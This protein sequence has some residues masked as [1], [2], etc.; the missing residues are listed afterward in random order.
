M[1]LVQDASRKAHELIYMDNLQ[2]AYRATMEHAVK[3]QRHSFALEF[4]T[5]VTKIS[6]IIDELLVYPKQHTPKTYLGGISYLCGKV[7]CDTELYDCLRNMG[8]NF[9]GNTQ[10]HNLK[11]IEINI[12]LCVNAYNR[13][14][15]NLVASLE[16]QELKKLI[17]GGLQQAAYSTSYSG[18]KKY[19]HDSVKES[20]CGMKK[21]I[22]QR[23]IANSAFTI[24]EGKR[25]LSVEIVNGDG[26]IIKKNLLSQKKYIHFG[27]KV[28]Y[29][30]TDVL[31]SLK[32]EIPKL[33]GGVK[34]IS[35]NEGFNGISL[36]TSEFCFPNIRVTVKAVIK[37]GL[38]TTK[39]LKCTV[40]KNFAWVNKD[41]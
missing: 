25:S 10:K 40:S 9:C 15:N 28:K 39:E 2:A 18:T 13:L 26:L 36:E 30:G 34:S 5:L 21:H 11:D 35:L 32:A 37:L 27:L 12:D 17:I 6:I 8:A 14:I 19:Y 23:D 31:K 4:Q 20:N 24:K 1:Q 16:V 41:S 29:K 38:F 3:K 33:N 7:L 22:G